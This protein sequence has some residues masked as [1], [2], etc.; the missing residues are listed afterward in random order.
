M[1][2]DGSAFQDE[3]GSSLGVKTPAA[4]ST[5][6][7][8]FDS[9]GFQGALAGS[10]GLKETP[11]YGAIAAPAPAA[12]SFNISGSTPSF[13]AP[14]TIDSPLQLFNP[15]IPSAPVRQPLA[16]PEAGNEQTFPSPALGIGINAVT[17]TLEAIPAIA[18]TTIA[19][20]KNIDSTIGGL[21]SASGTPGPA[22]TIKTPFDISRIGLSDT[23]GSSQ[24]QDTGT[25]LLDAYSALDAKNPG[26]DGLNIAKAVIQVPIGDALN[27]LATGG[28]AE[29]TA[30]AALKAT[31]YDPE[32]SKALQQLGLSPT[33]VSIDTLKATFVEKAQR[34]AENEDYTGLDNLGAAANT[35]VHAL[36][37]EGVPQLSS[38]GR[39]IQT[40]ARAATAPVDFSKG[41]PSIDLSNPIEPEIAPRPGETPALPG[42]VVEPGQAY[43]IGLSTQRVSRVGGSQEGQPEEPSGDTLPAG[44]EADWEENYAQEHLDI[45]NQI[46]DLQR[47]AK[48]GSAAFARSLEPQIAALTAQQGAIEEHFTSKYGVPAPTDLSPSSPQGR[49][50]NLVRPSAASTPA[51]PEAAAQT[52]HDE[53]LAPAA[54][55]GK[56]TVISGDDMKTYFGNDFTHDDLY[57]KAAFQTYQKALTE[58][59]NSVVRLTAGGPG[60][61][62]TEYLLPKLTENFDGIV[63]EST[64]GSYEGL[65]NQINA[66]R[67][68]DKSVEIYGLVSDLGRARVHTITREQQTGRPVTDEAFARLHAG[69]PAALV[70]LVEKGIINPEDIHLVDLRKKG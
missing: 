12:P 53:V 34:L 64:G 33:N 56:A 6:S 38:L 3:L 19:N 63:Y 8:S 22:A 1:A 65:V 23:E 28:L 32:V 31:A 37:G 68:A 42:T 35:V 14:N 24:V 67:E 52:Y 45:G 18:L 15:L 70:K 10:L 69:F 60:S 7:A 58:N 36:N 51:S 55:E 11:D 27:A 50:T 26:Q 25:R 61:G 17:R 62:K 46:S 9:A 39:I 30:N 41:F 4:V 40:A 54:A 29:D 43:P 44:A 49:T 57:S 13:E 48:A 16:L 59:P 66:A 5:P 20:F 47:Q 2:F 21:I